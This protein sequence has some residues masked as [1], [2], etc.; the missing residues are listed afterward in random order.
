MANPS[1]SHLPCSAL[2]STIEAI[3]FGL[4]KYRSDI[5]ANETIIAVT[6]P[7]T[8]N[9]LCI[10]KLLKIISHGT[11][12]IITKSCINSIP[13]LKPS[14]LRAIFPGSNCRLNSAA[15]KANPCTYPKPSATRA[16]LPGNM[17]RRAW[18]AVT[19]IVTAIKFQPAVALILPNPGRPK[20]K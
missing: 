14:M 3:K 15:P 17:G 6:V 12:I 11:I 10:G 18:I 5:Q 19:K 2:F 8:L 13:T 4:S 16:S 9:H 1:T 7:M 20:S